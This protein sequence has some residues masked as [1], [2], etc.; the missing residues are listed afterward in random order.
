MKNQLKQAFK[1]VPG[2][3][4]E[5]TYHKLCFLN[6]KLGK[7][8]FDGYIL[9]YPR[10]TILKLHRDTVEGDHW[11]CNIKLWGRCHF[12]CVGRQIFSMGELIHI[13]R[14]D[15]RLHGLLV[16]TKTIKLSF[17]VAKLN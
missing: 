6:I 3:V 16:F 12:S 7:W 14:P 9:K 8:G 15:K 10:N 13:F 17:G 5:T 1:W 2:R 4:S 11:R